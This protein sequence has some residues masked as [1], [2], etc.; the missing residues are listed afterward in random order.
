MSNYGKQSKQKPQLVEVFC[1]KTQKVGWVLR[2]HVAKRTSMQT[3]HP[4][5]N[6]PQ[7]KYFATQA[8]PTKTERLMLSSRDKL[9]S[10]NGEV[11]PNSGRAEFVPF[12]AVTLDRVKLQ[13][14]PSHTVPALL[15]LPKDSKVAVIS[16][17]IEIL[18]WYQVVF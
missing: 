3:R 6:V 12:E 13:S 17:R 10:S 14:G 11:V 5:G 7:R 4:N 15:Y 18:H 2:M 9:T 8:K 16:E 1:P